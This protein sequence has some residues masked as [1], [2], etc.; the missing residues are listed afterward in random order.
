MAEGSI[1]GQGNVTKGNVSARIEAEG[2]LQANKLS[3]DVTASGGVFYKFGLAVEGS[4]VLGEYSLAMP[5]GERQT[6][7]AEGKWEI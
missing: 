6:R 3:L 2:M 1:F 7:T 4:T 5:G